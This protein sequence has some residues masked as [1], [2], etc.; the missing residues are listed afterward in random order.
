MF[1]RKVG[2]G[3]HLPDAFPVRVFC[4]KG[5]CFIAIDFQRRFSICHE[6]GLGKL[7]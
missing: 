2:T 5:R 4:K 3:I 7:G 6:E 1:I